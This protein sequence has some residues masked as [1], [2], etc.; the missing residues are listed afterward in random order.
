MRRLAC[1]VSRVGLGAALACGTMAVLAAYFSTTPAMA[2]DPGSDPNC[3]CPFNTFKTSSGQCFDNST[4]QP[5]GMCITVGK[6]NLISKEQ[7]EDVFEQERQRLKARAEAAQKTAKTGLTPAEANATA[8]KMFFVGTTAGDPYGYVGGTRDNGTSV[9]SST[10]TVTG[11]SINS[12]TTYGGAGE[13]V[14]FDLSNAVGLAPGQ[15][16]PVGA[17]F[18]YQARN[19]DYA[20]TPGLRALG[21][22]TVGSTDRNIYT[23]GGLAR[24]DFGMSWIAGFGSGSWGD[25]DFTDKAQGSKGSFDSGGYL[26][27]G[28][29]GHTF[30]LA[31]RVKY[32]NAVASANGPR[33]AIGGHSV[34]LDLYGYVGAYNDEVGGFQERN[35]FRFGTEVNR[36]GFVGGEAKLSAPLYGGRFVW[37][38]F[39]AVTFVQEFDRTHTLNVPAQTL[40]GTAPGANVNLPADTIHFDDAQTYWGGRFGLDVLAANGITFGVNGWAG[41]TADIDEV[42]GRAYIAIPF[43]AWH[44]A[45]AAAKPIK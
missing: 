37:T 31:D 33:E 4:K 3:R 32:A 21:I 24:Y 30:T 29:G 14:P 35:G 28:A 11:Q 23:T 1:V 12:D 44:S 7:L 22:S 38:P 36:F 8:V 26:F 16:L 19:M 43:G 25:G 27:A 20:T 45:S 10:G 13:I 17:F 2:A 41:A 18:D 15:K 5:V 42:G 40:Q 34:L 6:D 39:A 9:T